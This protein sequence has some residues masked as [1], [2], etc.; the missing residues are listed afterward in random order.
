ME[1]GQGEYSDRLLV[2]LC[3]RSSCQRM[4][5]CIT[6]FGSGALGRQVLTAGLRGHRHPALRKFENTKYQ[7]RNIGQTKNKF[8]I[9]PD[10]LRLDKT[11]FYLA[12]SSRCS[13]SKPMSDHL[14]A[15]RLARFSLDSLATWAVAAAVA[16]I[17]LIVVGVLPRIPW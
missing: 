3:F 10:L 8:L 13:G 4:P 14:S 6:N 7:Y 5:P 12:D 9:F 1:I 15:H 16:L 17:V 11:I 2:P